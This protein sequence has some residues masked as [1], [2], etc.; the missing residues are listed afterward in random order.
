M[1]YLPFL[2]RSEALA[3]CYDNIK[4]YVDHITEISPGFITNWGLGDWVPVNQNSQAVH[5]IDLL[6]CG[7]KHFM[8]TAKLFGK[9]DDYQK[10]YQ[11]AANIKEEINSRFLIQKQ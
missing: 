7:C 8:K 10:Y 11:L 6:L 3:D 1:E 5:F 4:R 9:E 2:W